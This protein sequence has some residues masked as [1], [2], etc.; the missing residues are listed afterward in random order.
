MSLPAPPAAPGPAPQSSPTSVWQRLRG[1]RRRT[2]LLNIGL[3]LL[4]IIILVFA[5][6]TAFAPRENPN[7]ARTV[8]VTRGTVTA[9]VT[10][11]GNSESSVATP[12]SFVTNGVLKTVDVKPGDVVTTGQVLATIDPASAQTTLDSALAQLANAQAALAQAQAGPT[13]IKRQQ[14][15]LAITQAQQS[16]DAAND[17]LRTARKQKDLDQKST[18]TA[19]KNA[20]AKLDTD[21]R[22]QNALVNTAEQNLRTCQNSASSTVSS[23]M[24]GMPGTT[25]TATPTATPSSNNCTTE[26]NALTNA[27]NTRTSTLQADQQAITTAKQNQKNTLLNDQKAIDSAE[28]QVTSAESNV[29]SAQLSQQ[30]N[31]HPQTPEQI[32]QAR[33]N[34]DSAQVTVDSARRG[35]NETTLLAPQ[36]G[37]V[38]SVAN[39]VGEVATGGISAGSGGATTGSGTNSAANTAATSSGTG[40]IVIANPSQLAVTANIAE[41]DAAKVQLGQAAR[42]TFPATSATATGTVTQIT[43]QSTVTNN[44]V[45]YPVQVSLATA[46]PGVGVGNTASLSITTGTKSGVLVAPTSAITSTGNRHTVVVRRG[47]QD[48]TV[49]VEIGIVGDTTTEIVGGVNEGDQLVL[50]TVAT[51]TNNGFPRGGGGGGGGG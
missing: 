21:T 20:Q 4:V 12:V 42:I 44:V 23:M 31:L 41:A 25:T 34:V 51:S 46:P 5:L 27:R 17:T 18:D 26:K 2:L 19:I 24:S 10:A 50:P 7:P 13:D 39:K 36:D 3:A 40:F 45:Q 35:V 11:S 37:K 14:D 32:A 33:A 28:A 43:P 8:A 48:V 29:K 22:A 16:V 6:M 1:A 30:A 15:A 38:L 49:P 9:S 47:E